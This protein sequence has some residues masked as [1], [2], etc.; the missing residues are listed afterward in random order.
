MGLALSCF[1]WSLV[2]FTKFFLKNIL[3]NYLFDFHFLQSYIILV[4][5]LD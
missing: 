1:V 3:F 5:K 4:F 2:K